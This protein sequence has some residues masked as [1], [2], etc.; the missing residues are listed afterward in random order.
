MFWQWRWAEG[1]GTCAPARAPSA[2]PGR[3]LAPMQEIW[4]VL[5]K[6]S[7]CVKAKETRPTSLAERHAHA[8]GF[9]RAK[10]SFHT[11][12]NVLEMKVKRGHFTSHIHPLTK[13]TY[14][15]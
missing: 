13:I 3:H 2:D 8:A 11:D 4:G 1:Q 12:G 5:R 9:L 10:S 7:A 15:L 6:K 14:A